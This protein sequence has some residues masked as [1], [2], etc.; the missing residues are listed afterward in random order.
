MHGWGSVMAFE[1]QE[2]IFYALCGNIALNNLFNARASRNALSREL[3]AIM[4][5]EFDFQKP[6]NFGGLSLLPG[7]G[8]PGQ[9][10]TSSRPVKTITIDSLALP[11]C[12]FI[13]LD[14]EGM[15]PLAL[16]GAQKTILQHKPIIF[17]ECWA[18]GIEEIRK[19][20][21]G[22]RLIPAGLNVIGIH[23]ADR[24]TEKIQFVDGMVPPGVDPK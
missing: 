20:L 16:E 13:K 9:K 12:D 23:L 5:P 1:P 7:V 4:V 19:W 10:P 11:R 14:I 22:Y 6:A 21:P 2:R 3:G 17:A 8:K 15:E 24:I 18:C